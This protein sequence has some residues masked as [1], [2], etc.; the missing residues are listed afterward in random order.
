MKNENLIHPTVADLKEKYFFISQEMIEKQDL[1]VH[2]YSVIGSLLSVY[3][4]IERVMINKKACA[5]WLFEDTY[6]KKIYRSYSRGFNELL[7]KGLIKSSSAAPLADFEFLDLSELYKQNDL[8][9]SFY[10]I[11]VD[12]LRTLAK[13]Y[14]TKFYNYL[15]VYCNL[16]KF[17]NIN[18]NLDRVPRVYMTAVQRASNL[19]YKTIVKVMNDFNKDRIIYS[20]NLDTEKHMKQ[21]KQIGGTIIFDLPENKEDVDRLAAEILGDEETSS[22]DNTIS[23]LTN[24]QL[25]AIYQHL[26]KGHEVFY[27]E[28]VVRQVYEYVIEANKK[29][30]QMNEKFQDNPKHNQKNIRSLA[31]FA[32][33]S[34]YAPEADKI[35]SSL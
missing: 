30:A 27:D 21:I 22:G 12:D 10:S 15:G 2:T 1:S 31:P 9:K 28:A 16:I 14:G 8:S 4:P 6:D 33:Y 34:F 24:A 35:F 32:G 13:N 23:R 5:Y 11:K 3:F 20:V 18:R 17:I 26:K 19:N 25:A 7:Q 29:A